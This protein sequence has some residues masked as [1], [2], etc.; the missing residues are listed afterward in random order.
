MDISYAKLREDELH[1]LALR[2]CF[3]EELVAASGSG[4]QLLQL[5]NA[6]PT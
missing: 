3:F 2:D 4:L 6:S 5:P 1:L